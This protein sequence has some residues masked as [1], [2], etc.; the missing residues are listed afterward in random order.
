M[1]PTARLCTRLNADLKN[2]LD[3]AVQLVSNKMNSKLSGKVAIVTG[4][5]SGMGRGIAELFAR[6]GASIVVGGRDENRGQEVV[7]QINESGGSAIFVAGNISTMEGNQELVDNAIKH[8][9]QLHIL[10]AN[11]GILGTGSVT[12]VPIELWHQTIGTNLHSVFYLLRAGLPRLQNAGGGA[13]VVNGSVVGYKGD[14]H[15]PAYCASKGALVNF[16]RQVAIDYGPA[17][18]INLIASGPVETPLLESTLAELGARD[19][20][21]REAVAASLP[22]K[23]LGQPE[24]VAKAALFLASD[25]SSWIT[26]A[27]LA[28]DGGSLCGG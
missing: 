24:D 21:L 13:V 3:R 20:S 1:S 19:N 16:V 17:V 11:A 6:E 22:M 26:G 2:E 4:A 27:S 12:T 25:E 23:R 9:D 28:V 15:H 8:F 10:V 5:T 7:T 14:P 18:R